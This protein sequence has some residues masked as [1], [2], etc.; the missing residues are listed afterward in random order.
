MKV[1]RYIL[2]GWLLALLFGWGSLLVGCSDQTD[3]EPERPD[4]QE[5]ELLYVAGLTRT[6]DEEVADPMKNQF[7]QLFVVG[8]TTQS[9]STKY[10][11]KDAP[12][13]SPI[14]WGTDSKLSVKPGNDYKI[15]GFMPADIV[16]GTDHTVTIN[17]NTATMTINGLPTITNQDFCIVIGVKGG[18]LAAGETVTQGAFDYHAPEDTEEGYRVSL[19]VDHLLAGVQVKVKVGSEYNTLRT[20]RLKQVNLVR[21]DASRVNAV[22]PLVMNDNGTNPMTTV[23]QFNSPSGETLSFPV[24]QSESALGDP[25]QVSTTIDFTGYFTTDN[26]S[27]ISI[28]S[29][30]DVYDKNDHPLR[31]G[32]K[33]VN[34]LANALNG[35]VDGQMK[36]ITMTV[37]PT[38]LYVLSDWDSPM[39]VV[40]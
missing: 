12:D 37:A 32:C 35:V 40:E 16:S 38:Y 34:S 15:F 21:T 3:N 30:Y 24:F 39:W 5:G 11:G 20:I 1:Y 17:G 9:A 8:N 19:L 26:V 33:A 22:M 7:V 31:S 29:I 18:K 13:D 36:T 14:V 28:E 6:G 4:V 2:T 27:N 23:P 10:N 25:L